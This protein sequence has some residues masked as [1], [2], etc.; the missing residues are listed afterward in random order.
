MLEPM[1]LG[2]QHL[3]EILT[4]CDQSLEFASLLIWEFAHL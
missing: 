1:L 4:S 3:D 2:Y